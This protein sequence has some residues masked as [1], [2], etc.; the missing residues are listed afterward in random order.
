MNK[1]VNPAAMPKSQ[2]MPL[3]IIS[4]KG[5]LVRPTICADAGATEIISKL[6]AAKKIIIPIDLVFLKNIFFIMSK[7]KTQKSKLQVKNQNFLFFSFKTPL[8]SILDISVT[9]LNKLLT[10]F[11]SASFVSRSNPNQ[12]L[13]S[14]ADFKEIS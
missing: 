8:A 3:A 2:L 9:S 14:F 10:L 1:M 12:Y 11:A 4:L 7:V 6:A 13:V 5:L